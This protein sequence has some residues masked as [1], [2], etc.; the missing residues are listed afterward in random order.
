MGRHTRGVRWFCCTPGHE[1]LPAACLGIF[2]DG[3]EAYD[4]IPYCGDCA[5][6]LIGSGEYRVTDVLDADRLGTRICPTCAGTGRLPFVPGQ[7]D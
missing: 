3:E 2:D 4:Q 7:E 6:A 1:E 5:Q